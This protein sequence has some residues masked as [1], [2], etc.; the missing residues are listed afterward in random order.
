MTTAVESFRTSLAAIVGE[1]HVDSEP[2]ACAAMAVGGSVPQ[3]VVAPHTAE[4]VAAV[5]K[6]AADCD[7]AVIPR[8]SGTKLSIGSPPRR[9]DLALSLKELNH[10]R[11]YEPAD[12]TTSVEAGMKLG[13][14]QDFLGGDGLWLPL[15]PVGGTRESWPRIRRDRYAFVLAHHVTWFWE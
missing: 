11:H 6:F 10:V 9:Y 15:D 14:F 4:T 2:T 8:G 5:L 13:D 1:S 3:Y 7:L 12:L